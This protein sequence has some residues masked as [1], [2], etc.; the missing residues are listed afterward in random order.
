VRTTSCAAQG[1]WLNAE[2]TKVYALDAAY[3]G[4]GG[5][6]CVGGWIEFGKGAHGGDILRVNPPKII[7]IVINIGREPED[8]IA[9]YI[10]KDILAEGIPPKQ[11]F[12]DSTGRGTLGSSFAR[13]FM[14]ETPV[15]VE[16]GGKPSNRPVR[17]DL[18]IDDN[19]TE[20][21]KRCDEHYYDF[22]SELWFSV[23]YIIESEQLRELPE[24]VMREGCAR[25]YGRSKGNKFFIESKHDPKA[26]QR[27]VRSPDLFDWLATAI[28]G[29]RRLGFRIAR[30][31]AS[32]TEDNA[33]D[34]YWQRE[35]K[36][37]QDEISSHL[38]IH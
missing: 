6:R 8:Q 18:F 21:H 36:A 29:A 12:Y 25:E 33:D 3:S 5:D 16:F 26:R 1:E 28:E 30:L 10:Q 37:Y 14:A 22:V 23:R 24:D 17:H 20:R 38:L 7:P 11:V 35:Q 4:V 32:F 19:G 15:P 2:R 13:L 9:E 31:G 27:M 34:D